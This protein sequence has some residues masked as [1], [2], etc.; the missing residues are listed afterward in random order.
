MT[1]FIV[2]I[3]FAI[4]AAGWEKRVVFRIRVVCIRR[5][6]VLLREV[7]VKRR[8]TGLRF[9]CKGPVLVALPGLFT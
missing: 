5:L 7:D 1:C 3:G 2:D 6:V 4:K 8:G 9:S